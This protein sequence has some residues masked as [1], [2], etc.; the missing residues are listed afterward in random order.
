MK[1]FLSFQNKYIK[2]ITTFLCRWIPPALYL[3]SFVSSS[4]RILVV[5]NNTS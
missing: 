2:T 1:L 4:V 5:I 3:R